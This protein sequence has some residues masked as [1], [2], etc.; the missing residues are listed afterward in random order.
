MAKNVVIVGAQWGDEGKGK[1]IDLLTQHAKAVIR[2]QGG[3]NAGHTVVVN[4]KKTV[5]HLLPSGILHENVANYIGNGVILSPSALVSEIKGLEEQ[6][7][8]VRKRLQVSESCALL[9]PY[10]ELIDQAQEKALGDNAI[11][12]THRGI[13][14]AYVDKVARV[15][16]RASD[17]RNTESFI[18][19]FTTTFEYHNFVLQNY[20]GAPALDFKKI[21]DEVLANAE[22]ICPLL[23]DVSAKLL[24]HYKN[25]D[26][27][28]FEGAQGT[29]LDIDHGTY[30]FVTSSNTI[31]GAASVGT[32]F[33]P[34]Y[35][36]YVLGVSKVYTTRVGAGPFPTE[37]KDDVGQ[38]LAERGN[39]FGA[40]T[41]RPRRC[42][43]LDIALLRRS[44]LLNSI[45][46]L[47][48]TKLDVLDGLEKIKI[49]IG[50]NLHGKTIDLFPGTMADLKD[51]EPIYEE[52]SGWKE[53]TFGIR[54]F[55]DLPEAAQN[56]LKRIEEL[57]QLKIVLI[58]TGQEREDTIILDNPFA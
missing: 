22:I 35:L 45:S 57:L 43:W 15:G 23:T 36:D 28:L 27:L 5:L 37:L 50:Y 9:L 8:P 54:S 31:A 3:H 21:L 13:G 44:V 34:L 12:T 18:D 42:G 7:V 52:L 33:G 16:L 41:G 40:T 30:P 39:E 14:P 29:F 53:S 56:Y 25:G 1:L 6:G 51:C 24:R 32:G 48:I 46:A 49:C 2:F 47:G 19:K 55:N 38:R 17:L 10:H 58:A 4:G 11:G 20:Y 26:K